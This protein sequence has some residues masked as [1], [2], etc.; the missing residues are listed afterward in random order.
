MS[1]APAITGYMNRLT[2]RAGEE[3]VVY[4][5]S[6]HPVVDVRLVRLG[7]SPVPGRDVPAAVE[8]LDWAA[9]RTYPVTQ[10]RSCVGS[11]ATGTVD[12]AIDSTRGLT[13]GVTMWTTNADHAQP[14]TLLD[15][16]SDTGASVRLEMIRSR[17]SLYVAGR[18]VATSTGVIRNRSWTT[19]AAVVSGTRTD[20][21]LMVHDQLYGESSTTEGPGVDVQLRRPVITVAADSPSRVAALD[22][23]ARGRAERH[24]TGK[25]A[26]P[27][28]I[29]ASVGGE[30]LHRLTSASGVSAAVARHGGASW[31]FAPRLGAGPL[32]FLSRVSAGS[33]APLTLVNL[34]NQAVTGPSYDGSVVSFRERPDLYAA[35]HFHSTDLVDAGWE[36]TLAVS[37]PADLRSGVYGVELRAPDGTTDTIPFFVPAPLG[38]RTA[39]ICFML[40]TFTYLAY[41]NEDLIGHFKNSVGH[42]LQDPEVLKDAQSRQVYHDIEFGRSLYDRHIDGSGV[43]YSSSLRPILDMRAEYGFWSYPEGSGRAFSGDM[44][45]VEWLEKFGYEF[46]VVTEEQIHV[47]GAAALDGYDVVLTGSH[48]EYPSEAVLDAL[49]SYRSRG[50]QLCY[51]GGNGFYWV[52]GVVNA[53]APIVESRRGNAG[54]RSWDSPPGEVELFSSEE[55]GGLWRHRGRAPQRLFG[56]GMAAAGGMSRP[57]RLTDIAEVRQTHAWFFDGLDG[58]LIGD[59]GF[60]RGGASGDEI[61]RVDAE[62]GTPPAT[63]VLAASWG[64]DNAAQRA[65]EEV[66]QPLHGSTSGPNDPEIHADITYFE[67]PSGGAV[68][69]VGSIAYFGALL[70]DEGANNASRAFRNVLDHMLNRSA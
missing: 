50:G 38:V 43:H 42:R 39:R 5:T 67:T 53:T 20:L 29:S 34:P 52:T 59:R 21:H 14:Q 13:I 45:A 6:V 69:A 40:P 25:L 27:F 51:M 62:L 30:R 31:S 11:F 18:C 57:Y 37:L 16:T 44:Y 33:A 56:V 36:P 58:E 22:G 26:D 60:I 66:L 17:V 46:D 19:V 41:A 8:E 35:A 61:D 64:H 68:F 28:V 48:P 63:V 4:A 7:R 49:E 70:V 23:Y 15:L 9:E 32:R 2:Y 1:E 12:F 55:P 54:V 65:T 24:F 47:E 10:Q 3:V